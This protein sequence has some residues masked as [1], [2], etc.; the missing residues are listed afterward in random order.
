MRAHSASFIALVSVGCGALGCEKAAAPVAPIAQVVLDD[1]TRA[2]AETTANSYLDA[3]IARKLDDAARLHDA[4]M[5]TA[6][7]A[8]KLGEAFAAL[9]EKNGSLTERGTPTLSLADGYVIALYPS[10]FERGRTD[11]K[12]VVDSAGKIS[13]LWFVAPTAPP[14]PSSHGAT[15]PPAMVGKTETSLPAGVVARPVVT[16]AEGWPL[17]GSIT[18]PEGKGPFPAVVLVHGSGPHDFDETIGPNKPFRDLAHGLAQRGIATI[19][20]EKRT[21]T[22]GEKLAANLKFTVADE[23]IDDAVA[24]VATLRAQSEIAKDR[25]FIVGHS[26]GG[27][28]APRIAET[29]KDVRGLVVLAGNTRPLEDAIVAQLDYLSTLPGS[30]VPPDQ[31]TA[32]RKEAE[33]VR[34]LDVKK[35]QGRDLIFGTPASYW[36]DLKGYKPAETAAGLQMPMLFMQGARD[37]QVT[38]EDLRGWQTALNGRRDVM[39]RT[40]PSLNHLFLE[41]EGKSTPSEYEKEAHIPVFV[42]DD[43][44]SFVKR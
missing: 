34:T 39:F 40:Y 3:I 44:A 41:G 31:V 38:D 23:T 16:G 26:L 27:M 35:A 13:G 7:P 4:A 19:R 5:T 25:I 21:R 18:L 24:A 17:P 12:V 14:A 32:M 8:T 42:L 6:M 22:H 10:R 43:I 36:V 2:K 9:E 37:Y 1:A 33:R 29:A 30:P 28:L 11:V 15:P 20:Y